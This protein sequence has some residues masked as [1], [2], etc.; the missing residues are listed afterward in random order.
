MAEHGLENMTVKHYFDLQM[1][2]SCVL[3]RGGTKEGEKNVINL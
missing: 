1:L 2:E 3:Q